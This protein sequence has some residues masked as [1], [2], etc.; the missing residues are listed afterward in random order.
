MVV[1]RDSDYE[2]MPDQDLKRSLT[3]SACGMENLKF[4]TDPN[5]PIFRPPSTSS[6]NSVSLD[7][8]FGLTKRQDDT[9][10][11]G[12]APTVN[13]RSTI[14]RTAGCP[15]TRKVALVGVA[16]DCEY[17]R[18]IGSKELA[19]SRIIELVNGASGVFEDSFNI[20]LGLRNL[21]VYEAACPGSP[22]ALVPW[23][24]ACGPDDNPTITT[25]QR[26]N[27][28]SAWRGNQDDNNAF[29]TLMTA[30]SS[31]LEVGL[32]WLGQLCVNGIANGDFDVN[33]PQTQAVSGA[34]VVVSN[35][36]EWQVFA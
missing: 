32:A 13:L 15:N 17:T 16:A 23:N 2:P 34:S 18:E 30:C 35:S 4:N 19:T 29:W 11:G 20:T 10:G 3:G 1:I 6:Q 33:D 9:R 36:N 25:E 8:L 21:T 12:R 27:L 28:F 22:T 14:G 31:G 7:Y 5:H 26:L 24:V